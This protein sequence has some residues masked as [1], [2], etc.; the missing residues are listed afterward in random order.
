MLNYLRR[1]I[2]EGCLKGFDL[3]FLEKDDDALF[4]M[5]NLFENKFTEEEYVSLEAYRFSRSQ[6]RN[7]KWLKKYNLDFPSNKKVNEIICSQEDLEIWAPYI[8]SEYPSVKESL[9]LS[10]GCALFV[11]ECLKRGFSAKDLNC[12]LKQYYKYFPNEEIEHYIM[13][14]ID[15]PDCLD[16]AAFYI[17]N[18][19]HHSA[20]ILYRYTFIDHHILNS[21]LLSIINSYDYTDLQKDLNII[22]KLF[23]TFVEKIKSFKHNNLFEE[24]L[25]DGDSWVNYI[26]ITS[27][28]II[29]HNNSLPKDIYLLKDTGLT[30]ENVL[31]I[32]IIMK[33]LNPQITNTYP[34]VV[35]YMFIYKHNIEDI[36]T[37]KDSLFY[38]YKDRGI[39]IKNDKTFNENSALLLN[40]ISLCKLRHLTP[41]INNNDCSDLLIQ[42]IAPA[43][44]LGID[45]SEVFALDIEDIDQKERVLECLFLTLRGVDTRI[46]IDPSVGIDI[47]KRK[48][49]DLTI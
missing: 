15:T 44:A 48:R 12:F 8:F 39:N 33:G 45:L 5:N 30:V 19:N 21:D 16:K 6:I 42:F 34:T 25:V 17:D 41:S 3:T 29:K 18:F 47:L 1:I 20:K 13:G 14:F 7:F 28:N 32:F 9:I 2:Y 10:R 46:Y 38:Y 26:K 31:M 11:V 27:R 36:Y 24:S 43:A 23:P 40:H 4:I 22:R 35:D 49:K 37:E